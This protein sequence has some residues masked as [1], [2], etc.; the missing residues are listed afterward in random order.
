V[1]L[2][3]EGLVKSY[4]KRRVVNEVTLE[5]APG[6]VVGLLG[7]NGAGKTT[8]FYV[9][10]GL[11]GAERGRV[12]LGETDITH[13]PLHR[14]ARAGIGYLAQDPSVFR[15]MSVEDNLAAILELQPLTAAERRERLETLLESY[16]LAAMRRQT[17]QL[18]SGGERRR[19]E[20]ARAMAS[21][22]KF[23]LLDEPFTGVDPISISNLQDVIHDLRGRGLGILLTDHN[24][25]EAL[26]VT[27]ISHI[28]HNG[29]IL[30]SGTP[31]QLADDPKARQ[32]YLGE[33]F[34][35]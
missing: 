28:I 31:A 1:H 29:Q 34:S 18:L 19:V 13:W 10:V 32:F 30:T 6:Q 23:L 15:K 5:V 9:L 20:V 4:G 8:T 25:R 14:R 27:D 7:P 24:V 22:P 35:M 11:I 12:C 21:S 3:A 33:R 17:A 2:R 26:S 16:H